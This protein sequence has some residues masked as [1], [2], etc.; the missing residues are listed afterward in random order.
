[1]RCLNDWIYI[2]IL[3]DSRP[4]FSIFSCFHSPLF[5][6]ICSLIRID[7]NQSLCEYHT[8]V[9]GVL[10]AGYRNT[11]YIQTLLFVGAFVDK[12]EGNSM[13]MND[14]VEAILPS[15]CDSF[16][17]LP[18]RNTDIHISVK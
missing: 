6:F 18:V 14:N 3:F 1:M 11:T 17:I 2:Y 15:D 16:S 7:F 12:S 10:M 9:D 13:K 8:S 5:L 4:W